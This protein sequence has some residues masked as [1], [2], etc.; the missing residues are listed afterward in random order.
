MLWHFLYAD[1]PQS[2]ERAGI[3]AGLYSTGEIV[4][5]VFQG[6]ILS[7]SHTCISCAPFFP[8]PH[9]LLLLLL[10]Q[11]HFRLHSHQLWPKCLPRHE[12]KG[13]NSSFCALTGC[14][15]PV[16]S[17]QPLFMSG[18]LPFSSPNPSKNHSLLKTSTTGRHPLNCTVSASVPASRNQN[19][20][21]L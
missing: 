2:P 8:R 12:S 20:W 10:S 1:P 19:R 11:S 4:N 6:K 15:R 17:S 7:T 21:F 5:W 16:H 18:A 3:L 14:G 9:F 13:L